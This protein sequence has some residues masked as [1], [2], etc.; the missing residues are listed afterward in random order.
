MD[1]RA[2]KVLRILQGIFLVPLAFGCIMLTLYELVGTPGMD[3]FLL[4]IH[5]PITYHFVI[6]SS[7][8]SF[9]CEAIIIVLRRKLAKRFTEGTDRAGEVPPSG[10]NHADGP[11]KR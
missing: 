10:E 6:I 5:I 9:V 11:E 4:R 2:N 1:A 7:A 3:A 8:V